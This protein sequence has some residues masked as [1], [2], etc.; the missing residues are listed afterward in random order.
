M[1]RV[2]CSSA[3]YSGSAFTVIWSTPVFSPEDGQG[4]TSH[5]TRSSWEGV[6]IYWLYNL[7]STKMCFCSSSIFFCCTCTCSTSEGE[8]GQR[9][10]KGG[11]QQIPTALTLPNNSAWNS[12]EQSLGW[13]VGFLNGSMHGELQQGRCASFCCLHMGSQWQPLTN[14]DINIDYWLI[15]TNWQQLTIWH[16]V[17][18]REEGQA[19]PAAP[20]EGEGVMCCIFSTSPASPRCYTGRLQWDE[21]NRLRLHWLHH[22]RW[23]IGQWWH[24]VF[25][26]QNRRLES[27]LHVWSAE[28]VLNCCWRRWSVL[29]LPL[30]SIVLYS[31]ASLTL[32][33]RQELLA[34][35][36]VEPKAK[37]PV[38]VPPWLSSM[39]RL[40]QAS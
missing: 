19:A 36:Q 3:S 29:P 30:P 25:N 1:V 4:I 6:N 9:S 26:A 28:Y 40:R 8:Q 18:C 22:I 20:A 24:D 5:C 7:Y 10:C 35:W 39:R 16:C 13:L 37:A 33:A 21:G 15:D 34:R 27:T 17:Y 38:Q 23:I 12:T 32:Q 11:G 2:S 14:I 31:I